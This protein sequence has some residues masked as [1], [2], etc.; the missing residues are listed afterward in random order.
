MSAFNLQGWL[1]ASPAAYLEELCLGDIVLL[2]TVTRL[3]ATIEQNEPKSILGRGRMHVSE[4]QVLGYPKRR[5]DSPSQE[6]QTKRVKKDPNPILI[7]PARVD[8]CLC[9]T[10]RLEDMLWQ[11]RFTCQPSSYP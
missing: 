11:F 3:G 7:F 1:G 10:P 6:E 9:L 5:R 4:D 8:D 2:G